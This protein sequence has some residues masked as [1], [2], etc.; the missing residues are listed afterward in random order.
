MKKH[1]NDLSSQNDEHDSKQ[2][3]PIELPNS[4]REINLFQKIC[5]FGPCEDD[6]ISSENTK[7]A[8]AHQL[9]FPDRDQ[10]LQVYGNYLYPERVAAK[11]IREKNKLIEIDRIIFRKSLKNTDCQV[12]IFQCQ[13]EYQGDTKIHNPLCKQ[14]NPFRSLFNI[15][16]EFNDYIFSDKPYRGKIQRSLSMIDD[17]ADETLGV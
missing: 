1:L 7:N 8:V 12:F 10:N 5:L 15:A 16:L 17:R 6:V 2:D 14:V 3:L 11:L 4:P 13:Q 9:Y